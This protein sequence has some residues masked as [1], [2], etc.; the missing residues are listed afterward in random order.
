MPLGHTC[1]LTI[2][3]GLGGLAVH[4][5]HIG[6]R[7]RGHNSSLVKYPIVMMTKVHICI[8]M[9]VRYFNSVNDRKCKC[10]EGRQREG[11]MHEEQERRRTDGQWTG[12]RCL[13]APEFFQLKDNMMRDKMEAKAIGRQRER[14]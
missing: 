14:H 12:Q 7:A 2:Y 6:C 11:S 9:H 10:G 3:K 13:A 1:L 4:A 8:L 5:I